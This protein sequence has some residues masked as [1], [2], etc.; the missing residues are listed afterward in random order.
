[1]KRKEN[2]SRWYIKYYEMQFDSKTNYAET[3]DK[4]RSLSTRTM[5]R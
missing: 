3:Q 4:I 2:N 5:L 1:M